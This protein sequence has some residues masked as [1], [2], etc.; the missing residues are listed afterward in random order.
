M[1]CWPVCPDLAV[2]AEDGE[3]KGID[4]DHCKNCGM[5]VKAC[6]FG[7]LEMEE[8]PETEDKFKK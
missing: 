2:I 3:M 7:A 1:L 5:C 8:I 4:V 6:P